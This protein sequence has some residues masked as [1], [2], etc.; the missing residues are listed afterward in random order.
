[1]RRTPALVVSGLLLLAALVP[2]STRAQTPEELAAYIHERAAHHGVAGAWLEAV[3]RCESRTARR[4]LDPHAVGDGGQS[5]GLAQLH[6]R[7][8]RPLFHQRG[9]TDPFDPYQAIEFAAWAFSQGLAGHWT[10]ARRG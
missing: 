5:V 7:G 1:M 10:C 6:A 3:L 2:R 8:L 4:E 9:F